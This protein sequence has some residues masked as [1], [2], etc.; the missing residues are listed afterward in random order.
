M[1]DLQTRSRAP[2]QI[3]GAS[4]ASIIRWYREAYG[5]ATFARTVDR[6][7]AADRPHL[8]KMLLSAGWCPLAV[9]DRFLAACRAEVKASFGE[10]EE[11][12]DY[13]NIHEGGG[14]MLAVYKL[15]LSW[16]KPTAAL[17]RLP[18]L[19]SLIFDQGGVEILANEPGRCRF[20][21]AGPEEMYAHIN[22]YGIA[23]VVFLLELVGAKDIR[24]EILSNRVDQVSYE[25]DALLTYR[26]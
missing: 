16:F 10:S 3:R 2:V 24:A 18:A 21:C 4:I 5:D 23:G 12:F 25:I 11:T 26:I 1:A 8:R 19:I 6:L 22:R 7:P 20:R 15:V 14:R 9:W 17:S 13:R